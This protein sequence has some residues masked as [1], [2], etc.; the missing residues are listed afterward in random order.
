MLKSHDDIIRYIGKCCRAT[1]NFELITGRVSEVPIMFICF[2][3]STSVRNNLVIASQLQAEV[4]S[5]PK[6]LLLA[7]SPKPTQKLGNP[8][9][10]LNDYCKYYDTDWSEEELE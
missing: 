2:S 8:A 10:L 5:Q 9:T 3:C 7:L 6:T 1:S 4:S